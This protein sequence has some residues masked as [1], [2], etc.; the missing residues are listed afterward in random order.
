M[1]TRQCLAPPLAAMSSRVELSELE[2]VLN[3]LWKADVNRLT[4]GTHYAISPQGKAGYV[5]PGSDSARDCAARPLFIFVDE[6]ALQSRDTYKTFIALLDNYEEQT[7]TTE[8]VTAEEVRENH[9]FLDAVMQTAVMQIAHEFLA[10]KGLAS[11][12]PGKFK[13]HLYRIWFE[14]YSRGGCADS[15]GFEH[16]FV[17]ETRR[18]RELLGFHNWVQFY[19]QEKRGNVDYKG[20][21]ARRYKDKPD[22]DDH[23][24]TLQFSW[25]AAVKPAGSSFI[26]CSPE[27][28]LATYT[29]CFLAGGGGRDGER[30]SRY[31][32][33]LDEF[34]LELVCHR[35]GTHI[36]TVYPV[37][38]E[39]NLDTQA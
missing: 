33:R 29:L 7:G 4:P 2:G 35:H 30:S 9:R 36:G 19:L 34:R 10:S 13:Q 20:F 14:L 26:G 18:S 16:V 5:P 37:L 11:K 25:K 23:L 6:A 8:T 1:Y 32:L 27:F 21:V 22:E 28:E 31:P 12:D 17:G 3:E 38:L 39:H 15:S 24:L